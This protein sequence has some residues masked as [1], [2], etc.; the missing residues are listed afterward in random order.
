MDNFS[1]YLKLG[2]TSYDVKLAYALGTYTEK[3]SRM[4]YGVGTEVKLDPRTSLRVEYATTPEKA[5]Y[6]DA[7]YFQAGVIVRF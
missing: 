6:T 3:S 1:P 2:Y 5:G 7:S 4:I